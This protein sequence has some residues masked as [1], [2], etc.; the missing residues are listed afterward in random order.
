[1][2][3][4]RSDGFSCHD[5]FTVTYYTFYKV[6]PLIFDDLERKMLILQLTAEIITFFLLVLAMA[7]GIKRKRQLLFEY[8]Y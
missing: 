1:M 8:L 7:D 4:H 5:L 2:Y 6:R 3:Q